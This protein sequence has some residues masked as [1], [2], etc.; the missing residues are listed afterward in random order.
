MSLDVY[1][2]NP[3]KFTTKGTG[4]FVRRHGSS[5]ELS[6]EEAKEL[7]P[8][9][10]IQEQEFE[11]DDLFHSN[12]THNLAE[13]ADQAGIYRALWRPEEIGITE[14]HQLI[15]PLCNGLNKLKSDRK[16]F[17]TFNPDNGWGSYDLLVRFVSIYLDACC[18]F[19]DAKV[20]VSR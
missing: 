13:M 2:K 18:S 8:D 17:E 15:V 11:V 9:I 7:Y 20:E 16:W 12:I 1:L 4:I 6:L 10:T 3:T 14:A 19:P 5:V